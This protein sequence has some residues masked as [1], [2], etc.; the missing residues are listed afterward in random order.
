MDPE[1]TAKHFSLSLPHKEGQDNVTNLLRH[2]ANQLDKDSIT[3]ISDIV[4]HNESDDD[5]VSWPNF[6][7]YY[8]LRI[9]HKILRTLPA[10]GRGAGQCTDASQTFLTLYSTMS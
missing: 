3:D 8:D 6:T 7:V 4:F 5:G 10:T 9:Q 2:L 1:Y